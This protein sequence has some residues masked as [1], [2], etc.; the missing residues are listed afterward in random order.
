MHRFFLLLVA[1]TQLGKNSYWQNS[2]LANISQ[3]NSNKDD[4]S[5]SVTAANP[6]DA[7]LTKTTLSLQ[8]QFPPAPTAVGVFT[9]SLT[10]STFTETTTT[11]VTRN[12]LAT[13]TSTT[14]PIPSID[15]VDN[16]GFGDSVHS[17]NSLDAVQGSRLASA[18][19]K[20]AKPPKPKELSAEATPK[21]PE[22]LSF[23][24]KKRKFEESCVTKHES[25]G[26]RSTSPPD[27]RMMANCDEMSDIRTSSTSPISSQSLN[28]PSATT[29]PIAKPRTVKAEIRQKRMGQS[30]ETGLSGPELRAQWRRD[31]L[32][33]LDDDAQM[34]KAI[35]ESMK[36]RREDHHREG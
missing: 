5:K 3:N 6:S 20:P 28:Q 14:S 10:K 24:E 29:N 27:N 22:V 17:V 34:A 33:S 2:T 35:A 15:G 25:D 8:N 19:P 23:S 21:G 7:A 12:D 11:R 36:Q 31:R 30:N 26:K 9:E 32:K 13:T 1:L 4:E 16:K 18:T